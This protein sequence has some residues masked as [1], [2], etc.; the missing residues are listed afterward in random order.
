MFYNLL[1]GYLEFNLHRCVN[2]VRSFDL[3]LSLMGNLTSEEALGNWR[4]AYLEVGAA[5]DE[6]S[7]RPL[8]FPP[9]LLNLQA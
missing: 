3:M 9:G 5:R 8:L 2:P 4:K 6:R 7:C 1:K